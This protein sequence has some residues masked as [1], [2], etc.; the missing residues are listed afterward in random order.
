MSEAFDAEILNKI[1]Q[2]D[3]QAI[4]RVFNCSKAMAHTIMRQYDI[5]NYDLAKEIASDVIS[6]IVISKRSF[7]EPFNV[8]GYLYYITKSLI[9]RHLRH[10]IHI[11]GK[12]LDSE[13]LIDM[14][15]LLDAEITKYEANDAIDICLGLM[16]EHEVHLIEKIRSGETAENLTLQLGYKNKEVFQV[17]KSLVIRKFRNLLRENGID[18]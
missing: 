11:S 15:P 9:C 4:K 7:L 12:D 1:K 17:R 3:Q 6:E 8:M 13:Y 16:K 5:K 14:N 18:I 10:S 2:G